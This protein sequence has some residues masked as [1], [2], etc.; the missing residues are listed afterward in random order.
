MRILLLGLDNAGKTTML[1][2]LATEDP[3]QTTPTLVSRRD[4]ELSGFLKEVDNFTV[5]GMQEA[6]LQTAERELEQS[7]LALALAN[8]M[9][10]CSYRSQ[11]LVRLCV[12]LVIVHRGLTSR[13][14]RLRVC[15]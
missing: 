6:E 8:T 15:A 10:F 14:C 1:R 3:T 2:K 11:L 5:K 12:L 7:I 4:A 9:H 13:R